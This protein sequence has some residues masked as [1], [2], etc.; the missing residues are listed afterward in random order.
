M[1]GFRVQLRLRLLSKVGRS[2]LS[3]ELLLSFE[4][5]ATWRKANGQYVRR[6]QW[7]KLLLIYFVNLNYFSFSDTMK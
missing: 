6:N 3:F 7:R 1:S 5:A 4:Q 2:S